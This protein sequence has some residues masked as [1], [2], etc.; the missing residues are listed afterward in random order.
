M[1]PTDFTDRT[2]SG[3]RTAPRPGA[4]PLAVSLA[5][6]AALVGVLFAVSYPV[7][8]ASL[9]GA[10]AL[11]RFGPSL[12]GATGRAGG[13]LR[14][15]VAGGLGDRTVTLPLPGVDVR[16]ELRSRQ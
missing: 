10:L 9:G 12:A 15:R 7:V 14:K 13:T 4:P 8:A 5:L 1:R 6:S 3:A 16:V 2:G 11:A